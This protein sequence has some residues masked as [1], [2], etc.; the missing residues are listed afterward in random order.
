MSP[1]TP[2]PAPAWATALLAWAGTQGRD[3]PWRATRDPW[4]VLVSEVMLQQ[5]QVTRVI[6]RYGAFLARF[7]D[8]PTCAEAPLGDVLGLWS[9]LGYN[10]R[11]LHLHAAARAV[12]ERHGGRLPADLDALLAL[13][14]VG[15]DTARAILAFAF[16]RPVGVVDTNAARVLARAVAGR[17]LVP[18]EVQRLADASVPARES[19][20]YNQA[21]LDLG[22]TVCLSRRPGCERCPVR[23]WCAWSATGFSASDPALGTAGVSGRQS[24]F[25]GSDREGRG[26]VIA[27]LV[28]GPLPAGEIAGAAGWPEDPERA[29]RVVS[30]L[31]A[32]GL[33]VVDDDGGLR[34]PP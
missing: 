12:T 3:L 1:A 20:A 24:R 23:R 21:V 25:A 29:E 26:R 32:D 30:G 5:T 18:A 2:P 28:T 22:A 11:A 9:G 8:P 4:A 34:L 6:P 16:E 13:P 10:R 17:P 15:A 33:A 27:A 7:P 19:W 14:G 31:V